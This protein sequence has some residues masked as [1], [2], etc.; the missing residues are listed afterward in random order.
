MSTSERRPALGEFKETITQALKIT[1][2]D[3]E[4]PA[5][6]FAR[7]GVKA[8]TWWEEDAGEDELYEDWRY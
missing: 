8:I 4:S 7:T 5:K 2:G 6:R 1:G 3:G